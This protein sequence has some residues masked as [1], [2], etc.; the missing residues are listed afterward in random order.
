MWKNYTVIAWRNM[1]RHKLYTAINVIGLAVGI[2][3]CLAIATIVHYHLNFD[4]FHA[5]R[6]RI[7]R[8]VNSHKQVGMDDAHWGNLNEPAP[9]QIRK[10]IT[11]LETV[12][13]FHNY[14]A[15]VTVPGL[16]GEPYPPASGAGATARSADPGMSQ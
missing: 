12:A 13:R 16:D 2:C 10:E 9:V 1:T 3:S 5:D 15:A 7:Y 14:N 11:G 4:T 6:D 8:L